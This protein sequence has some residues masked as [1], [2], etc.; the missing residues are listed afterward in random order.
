[1]S[2]KKAKGKRS[3]TRSLLRRNVRAKTTVNE[4]MK[5]VKVG[6]TV[7]VIINSSKHQGIPHKRMYGK[8][9]NVVDFQGKAPV[10]EIYDGNLKKKIITDKVHIKQI[11]QIPKT[12][13]PKLQRVIR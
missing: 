2:C 1:M 5:P 12:P 13:K 9:G 3:K 7:Q 8:T 10:I 11:K 4:I 6:D